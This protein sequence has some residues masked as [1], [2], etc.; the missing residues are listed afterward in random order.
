MTNLIPFKFEAHEIRTIVDTQ[1]NPWF[2]ARDVATML[3]YANPPEA[4]R[5]HCKRAR[6]IDSIGVSVS[7]TLQNQTLMIPES[8]VNRLINRSKLPKAEAIQDWLCEEVM[9]SIRKTGAYQLKAMTPAE[10]LV[11]QAQAMLDVERRQHALEARQEAT[12]GLAHEALHLAKVAEA[13][14]QAS[15]I[16]SED[17][18]V[19]AW[20]NLLGLNLP[21]DTAIILGRRCS[22]LS[23]LRGAP[24]GT[25]CDPRFGTVKTY[26]KE[27]LT[28][29]FEVYYLEE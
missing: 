26:M 17:Y 6:A 19:R 5:T 15:T 18:T 22:A 8:D 13:K 23:K 16:A 14:A 2:V 25:A 24:T 21:L 12:D 27:I 3:G 10:M 28:E 7:L 29:V 9:P 4:I 20:G 11:A 1:G